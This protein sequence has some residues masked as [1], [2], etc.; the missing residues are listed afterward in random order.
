MKGGFLPCL[1]FFM[2]VKNSWALFRVY[3]DTGYW[4]YLLLG[5]GIFDAKFNGIRDI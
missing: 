4:P 3:W 2:S 5:Y 1:S